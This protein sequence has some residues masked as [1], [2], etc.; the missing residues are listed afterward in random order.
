[1]YPRVHEIAPCED[2]LNDIAD[3]FDGQTA[4]LYVDWNHVVPEGNTLVAERMLA[5]LDERAGGR[6]TPPPS[7]TPPPP[8]SRPASVRAAAPS[9]R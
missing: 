3:V 8:A 2:H 1:M 4:F 9:G 7:K 5:V 6:W